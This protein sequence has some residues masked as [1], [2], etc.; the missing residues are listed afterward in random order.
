MAVSNSYAV[1]LSSSS[2]AESTWI[3]QVTELYLPES[4]VSL[5]DLRPEPGS[6]E[7]AD[8]VLYG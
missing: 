8:A 1:D 5:L 4:G 7:N 3:L 2:R 6:S